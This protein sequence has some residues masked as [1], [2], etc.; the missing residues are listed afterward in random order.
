MLVEPIEIP[1]ELIVYFLQFSKFTVT[2][3]LFCLLI[4]RVFFFLMPCRTSKE[5]S[6][7]T[8]ISITTWMKTAKKS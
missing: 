2:A 6:K 1:F 3:G 4:L 7:L 8:Q 5:K